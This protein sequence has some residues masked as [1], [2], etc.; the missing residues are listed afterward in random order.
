MEPTKKE[1]DIQISIQQAPFRRLVKEITSQMD[2]S[3]RFF[4]DAMDALQVAAED[5]MVGLFEDTALLSFHAKRCTIMVKDMTLAR[6]IRG[7]IPR[8]AGN[9]A[10]QPETQS[11]GRGRDRSRKRDRQ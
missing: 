1:S 8:Y 3:I 10:P 9:R 2:P 4:S 6:R 7:D 11:R 5:Y